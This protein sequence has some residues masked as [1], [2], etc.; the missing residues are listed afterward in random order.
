MVKKYKVYLA[1]R[2]NRGASEK[3]FFERGKTGNFSSFKEC[4]LDASNIILNGIAHSMNWTSV[5]G[6]LLGDFA[7]EM[8]RLP[9]YKNLSHTSEKYTYFVTISCE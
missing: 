2:S 3:F 1:R 4:Y 9:K 8:S 5:C 6:T 7:E